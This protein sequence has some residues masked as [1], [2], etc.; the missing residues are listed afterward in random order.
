MRVVYC[1]RCGT[2]LSVLHKAIPKCAK[3]IDIVEYHTCPETPVEFDLT[4]VDVPTFT[5]GKEDKF[6][7]NLDRLTPPLP[8]MSENEIRDHRPTEHI[9]SE[10]STTAPTNL[11]EH[12]K[13]MKE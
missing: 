5:K 3:I 8:L 10:V 2:R 9:K 1:A 7:Q 11:L 4:P 6:V 12:L 13:R